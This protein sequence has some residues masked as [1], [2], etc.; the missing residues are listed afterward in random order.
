MDHIGLL[1]VL[2]LLLLHHEA[3]RG[4]SGRSSRTHRQPDQT[5]HQVHIAHHVTGP[6]DM[7]MWQGHVTW[8]RDRAT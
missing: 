6:R 4:G 5:G 1:A 7:A 3:E 8:Q 2:Q